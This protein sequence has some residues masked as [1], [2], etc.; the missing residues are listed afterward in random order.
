MKNTDSGRSRGF[1]FVTFS[2]PTNV[3]LVLQ[4][5]PHTLDGRTIDPKP[6]NPRHLQKPKRGAG[7]P[8]VFLGGLP[9]NV[10][11]TELKSFFSRYGEVTE[12]IIMYDQEKKK[13][14]GFGF[15]SFDN[16]DA[17]D[18]C[19]QEHYI[20]LRGKQVEVKRAEPRD[21]QNSNSSAILGS[22]MSFFL[23]FSGICHYFL[24]NNS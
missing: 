4:N 13:S 23:N 2:N 22:L 24:G 8:K 12:I 17:V 18:R 20:Y 15:L 3:A 5:G 11:E 1:G 9:Q 21:G 19:V 14:R 16:D 6:C 7:H 10:T